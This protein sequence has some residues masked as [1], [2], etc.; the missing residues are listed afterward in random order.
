MTSAASSRRRGEGSR[1]GVSGGGRH[2][3]P[4]VGAE[5]LARHWSSPSG[6]PDGNGPSGRHDAGGALHD[7]RRRSY[8]ARDDDAARQERHHDD[9]TGTRSAVGGGAQPRRPRI[10][11]SL[12]THHNLVSRYRELTVTVYGQ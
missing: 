4:R 1:H 12:D 5:R 10:T 7:A 9:A 3:E 11:S 6:G 8:D 2:T